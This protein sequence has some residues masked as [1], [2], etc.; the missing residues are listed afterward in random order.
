MKGISNPAAHKVNNLH[1][2][3]CSSSC[4]AQQKNFILRLRAKNAS[5]TRTRLHGVGRGKQISP[6]PLCGSCWNVQ[7][8]AMLETGFWVLF[9]CGIPY[10]ECLEWMEMRS[11]S[12]SP[13]L[14]RTPP[15]TRT[16]LVSLWVQSFTQHVRM[17]EIQPRKQFGSVRKS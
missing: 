1:F 4:E 6:R 2:L 5:E 7:N 11:A 15:R 12:S 8:K 14:L 9:G 17:K 13:S 16:A 3:S 10:L